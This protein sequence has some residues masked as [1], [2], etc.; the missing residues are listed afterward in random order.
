MIAHGR[1]S[2]E[3]R[4]GIKWDSLVLVE[5]TDLEQEACEHIEANEYL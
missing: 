3:T 5:I 2:Q 4:V 1:K